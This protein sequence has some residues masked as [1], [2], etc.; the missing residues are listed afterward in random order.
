M[1]LTPHHFLFRAL[2][3]SV[4]LPDEKQR[5]TSLGPH[6]LNVKSYRLLKTALMTD[7][8]FSAEPEKLFLK[9]LQLKRLNS[10]EKKRNKTEDLTCL[11]LHLAAPAHPP[12][13]CDVDKLEIIVLPRNLEPLMY[14]STLSPQIAAHRSELQDNE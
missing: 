11:H 1:L 4:N 7:I 9:S 12:K 10:R 3:K 2:M 6:N 8:H 13:I 14:F 5:W